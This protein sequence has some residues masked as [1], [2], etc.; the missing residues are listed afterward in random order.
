MHLAQV[1]VFATVHIKYYK[2]IENLKIYIKAKML[3]ETEHVE[4]ISRMTSVR[5]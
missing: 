2:K 4:K 1:A 3:M 5:K